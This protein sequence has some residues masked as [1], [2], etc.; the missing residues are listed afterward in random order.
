MDGS[1]R[2]RF[3]SASISEAFREIP[4]VDYSL[5]DSEPAKFDAQLRYALAG[6]GFMLLANVPGFDEA[7]QRR[8]LATGRSFFEL[9]DDMQLHTDIRRSKHLRG[10]ARQDRVKDIRLNAN[11][12]AFHFGPERAEETDPNAP[13]WKRVLNGANQW[14]DPEVLPEFR[15]TIQEYHGRCEALGRSLGKLICRMLGVEESYFTRYFDEVDKTDPTGTYFLSTL[16]FYPPYTSIPEERR[17]EVEEGYVRGTNAHRDDQ[18]WITMLI[19][20]EAGLEVL[21]HDGVWVDVPVVPGT[22]VVNIGLVLADATGGALQAT[23]HRVNS[24]KIKKPRLTAPYFLTPA[25]DV[26]VVP[27]PHNLPRKLASVDPQIV[28]ANAI[29]DPSLRFVHRRLA[30][31]YRNAETF[32]PQEWA[33]LNRLLAASQQV[34]LLQGK[35]KRELIHADTDSDEWR[36]RLKL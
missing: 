22:V 27:I 29:A 5:R 12:Q 17:Q 24:L 4:L 30:T 3:R 36:A 31:M 21:S 34:Y 28:L 2:S 33:L 16:N 26:P 13:L 1:G 18:S 8:V 19:Q 14:P 20:D 35:L 10:S 32:W 15:P 9:P 7:Y 25:L 11:L 23:V 6:C